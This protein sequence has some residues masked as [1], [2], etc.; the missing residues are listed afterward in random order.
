VNLALRKKDETIRLQILL[1]TELPSLDDVMA[2]IEV[3]E[4]R[5]TVMGFQA[6]NDQETKAF[7][8]YYRN[9]NKNPK[10]EM[11]GAQTVVCV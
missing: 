1:A 4:T 10:S 3:E 2:R 6:N 5:R 9:Q 8:S 11:K 7:N